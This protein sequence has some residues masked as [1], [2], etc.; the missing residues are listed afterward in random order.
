[1]H[2]KAL[3]ESGLEYDQVYTTNVVKCCPLAN[4]TPA[5]E[6][7]ENCRTWLKKE[8]EIVN[9]KT[10]ICLGRTAANWFGIKDSLT[11]ALT[12]EYRIKPYNWNAI[13]VGIE[14][15]VSSVA[16]SEGGSIVPQSRCKLCG[17]WME[18]NKA[19][20]LFVCN[21]CRK[22]N[23]IKYMIGIKKDTKQLNR[24]K[25]IISDGGC[26]VRVLSHPAFALRC[27]NQ[28]VLQWLSIFKLTIKELRENESI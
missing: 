9:P 15:K 6:E 2:F 3:K 10:I 24:G 1:M 7:I 19:F 14:K 12:K 23:G 8:I 26:L 18:Y 17:R 13:E 5:K 21:D 22:A 20:R 16:V 4:R 11:N 28:A 25:Y 27:G